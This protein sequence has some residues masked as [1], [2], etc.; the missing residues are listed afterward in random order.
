VRVKKLLS[1]PILLE[2]I[3]YCLTGLTTTL[4]CWGSVIVFVEIFHIHYLISSNLATLI[5][6]AYSYFVNKFY[7]FRTGRRK[8][9]VDVVKFVVLQLLLLG[10][11][12]I[13]LYLFVGKLGVH[14]LGVV[15]INAVLMVL[16]NFFCQKYYVFSPAR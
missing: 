5:A 9:A 15:I 16:I 3:R 2:G 14:Y 4:V 7:V 13:V 12:N 1:L 10:W 11:T 6:W 8:D